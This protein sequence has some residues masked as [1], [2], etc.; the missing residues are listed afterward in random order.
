MTMRTVRLPLIVVAAAALTVT[1]SALPA[2]AD[3]PGGATTA[4]TSAASTSTPSAAAPAP[5]AASPASGAT[6][7]TA[8]TAS[9]SPSATTPAPSATA[10]APAPSGAP[11]DMTVVLQP[12]DRGELRDLVRRADTMTKAQRKDALTDVAPTTDTRDD[13]VDALRAAGLHVT[14]QDTWDVQVSGTVAQAESVFGVDLAGKGDTLHPTTALDLPSGLS[15]AVTTVLGLDQRPVFE[16]HALPGGRTPADLASAYGVTRSG[17]TGAGTTVATVQFSGWSKSDLTTYA[18][19]VGVTLPSITQVAVDG[20]STTTSV[21]GGGSEVALDQEMLFATAPKASQRVYVAPNSAQGIYDA[22]DRVATDVTSSGIVALSTS[23]GMCESSLS[24][25]F[26]SAVQDAIDRAVV[27]GA[28]TFAASGDDGAYDCGGGTSSTPDVDFP[29]VV[30]SVVGVGG[31]SLT[32]SGT[33]WRETAWS[34]RADAVGSGGG[35]STRTARPTYQSGVGLPGSTRLVPDI[36]AVADPDTGP[37]VYI[38]AEGGWVLG[39]GTSAAAPIMAGQLAATLS[40]LGCSTGVGDVHATLYGNRGDFRDVT[41]GNNLLYSATT[42][43][44]MAT[45]LG[46]PNWAALAT[47]LPGTSSC[48]TSLAAPATLAVGHSITSPNQQYTLTMQADGN[49][50]LYGNGRALWSSGTNG[51]GG[52]SLAVQADGNAVIYTA[53]QKAVWQS[54]TSGKGSGAVLAVTNTG[55]LRLTRGSTVL[56]HTG[57]SGR[58]TLKAPVTLTGGQFI[59]DGSGTRQFIMQADGNLVMY[60]GGRARWATNTSKYHGAYMSLQAD[61]NLVVYDTSG[62]ARWASNTSRAGSGTTLVVQGNGNVVLK[63]GSTGIWS[64]GTKG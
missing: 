3:E 55:D 20:A 53:A 14:A 35:S 46:S 1:G 38:G 37:G 7:S 32:G 25:S 57:L 41:S 64:T 15:G 18:N 5:S 16:H 28:T 2:V 22:Y 56:W 54:R 33:S 39:G 24:S 11:I 4:T 26:E 23:W 45:G 19:A 30:P 29:A 52:T 63:K 27:A 44:D 36:S 17:S 9:P 50:V 43:Y 58:D 49:L 10:T 40:S 42:G 13:V 34:D 59:Q 62:K 31:T 21:D 51:R 61:G 60:I 6:A 12:S 48:S 47:A 8:P